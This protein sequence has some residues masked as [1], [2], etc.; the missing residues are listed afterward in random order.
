MPL[1]LNGIRLRSQDPGANFDRITGPAAR[2]YPSSRRDWAFKLPNWRGRGPG[3]Y[4]FEIQRG[5]STRL[6]AGA[7]RS[8]HGFPVESS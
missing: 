2:G 7:R 5:S 6:E 1:A 4:V 3:R 8:R